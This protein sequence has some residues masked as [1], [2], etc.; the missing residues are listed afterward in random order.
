MAKIK[1]IIRKQIKSERLMNLAVEVDESFIANDIV[2]HN[3][4]SYLRA[5]LKSSKGLERLEVSTLSPSATAKKS[6]TL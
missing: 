2:V 3:C 4:K 5:N 6:I 1:S